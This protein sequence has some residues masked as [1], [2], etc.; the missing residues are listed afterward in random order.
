MQNFRLVTCSASN[1]LTKLNNSVLCNYRLCDVLLSIEK[2][3]AGFSFY[4]IW[5]D[6][7][8]TGFYTIQEAF[9]W[10]MLQNI[11][12][13]DTLAAMLEIVSLLLI[14]ILNAWKQNEWKWRSKCDLA[15][16]GLVGF[17]YNMSIAPWD[18]PEVD[19]AD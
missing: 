10:A 9:I 1:L 19:N 17:Y 2:E 13:K 7:N 4:H 3:K 14:F 8:C 16:D 11:N 12:T 18:K 15:N 6:F 5:P